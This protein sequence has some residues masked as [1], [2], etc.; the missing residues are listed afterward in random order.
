MADPEVGRTAAAIA[1]KEGIQCPPELSDD[2]VT[3][4]IEEFATRNKLDSPDLVGPDECIALK[5]ELYAKARDRAATSGPAEV[6]LQV[7][8]K[9]DVWKETRECKAC[10]R[11]CCSRQFWRTHGKKILCFFLCFPCKSVL[12]CLS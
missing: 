11:S 1:L 6:V 4:F 9:D 8:E 10:C 12:K 5:R 7:T 2:E 3:T